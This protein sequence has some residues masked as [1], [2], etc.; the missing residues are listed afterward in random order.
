[1]KA[2]LSIEVVSK[3]DGL[4]NSIYRALL[5]ESVKPP[6]IECRVEL[7]FQSKNKLVIDIECSRINLLRAVANS[8][9]GTLS[10]LIKSLEVLKVNE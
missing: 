7:V 8:Y 6:S 3:D 1:M 5:P 9:L 2:K 4:L 10:S